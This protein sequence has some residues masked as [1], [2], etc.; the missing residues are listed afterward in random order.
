MSLVAVCAS[1]G[2]CGADEKEMFYAKLDSVLNQW[3]SALAGTHLLSWATPLLS[4]AL[5]ELATSYVLVP[6]ALVPGT[7]TALS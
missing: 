5:R 3:I 2:V 4:L 1:T 7:P 6:I